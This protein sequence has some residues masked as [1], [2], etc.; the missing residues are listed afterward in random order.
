MRIFLLVIFSF[1]YSNFY[2]QDFEGVIR[3]S[4]EYPEM[5]INSFPPE[6]HDSVKT[7]TKYIKG[8]R[9]RTENFT[10]MGKQV[11][12]EKIGSDTSYLMFNLMG[13]NI[14]IEVVG[15]NKPESKKDSLKSSGKAPKKFGYKC[16]K[17]LYTK[18]GS[19][20][21]IIYT[22]G[23]SS[24]YGNSFTALGGFALNYPIIL[25]EFETILY[26][27]TEITEKEISD[28]LFKIPENF[29]VV[30]MEEFSKMIGG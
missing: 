1:L 26:T 18:H 4:V 12:I 7:S 3:F 28:S 19:T 11:L 6:F 15:S 9:V 10:V 14:A 8:D 29:R 2:A 25:S 24:K 21:E 17:A 27:C 23:V 30:S 13:E 20:Y 16:K 22:D 5:M